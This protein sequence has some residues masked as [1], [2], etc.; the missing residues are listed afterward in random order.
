MTFIFIGLIAALNGQTT[1]TNTSTTTNA[2]N[3]TN[4]KT[5]SSN[6]S[7][8]QECYNDE[9]VSCGRCKRINASIVYDNV[10]NLYTFETYCLSCKVASNLE[11]PIT[12]ELSA[13]DYADG[14]IPTIDYSV[15][16]VSY[17]TG[18][19]LVIVMACLIVV[20][21]LGFGSYWFFYHGQVKK[22]D[23]PKEEPSDDEKHRA[24][25]SGT[26]L[27]PKIGKVDNSSK[28]RF[29]IAPALIPGKTPQ[30]I[31]GN[32]KM[33][34]SREKKKVVIDDDTHKDQSP[35]EKKLGRRKNKA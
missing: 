31:I 20:F 9:G 26:L 5:A 22:Q 8:E 11:D 21:G 32:D 27:K 28:N 3:A 35:A 10:T 16:C 14:K 29:P 23:P 25:E 12:F 4:L 2:T 24:D 34:E 17:S 33:G 1:T 19:I 18:V 30:P 13:Q 15:K 6:N 7:V